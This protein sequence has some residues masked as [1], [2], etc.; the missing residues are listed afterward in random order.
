[1]KV[2]EHA[3]LAGVGASGFGTACRR[4]ES[5]CVPQA[6]SYVVQ[7]FADL[8]LI[9]VAVSLA[10]LV[11]WALAVRRTFGSAA[12]SA[13]GVTLG[14]ARGLGGSPEAA[15][16]RAGLVTLLAI[17]VIFGVHSTIDWTWFV[18]GAALPALL[19]AG[20]LAGR[21]PLA[22]EGSR[23]AGLGPFTEPGGRLGLTRR[24]TEAPLRTAGALG[25]CT[26]A[27]LAAWIVWQPQRSWNAQL[28]ATSALSNGQAG[29]ALTDAR[30]AVASEPF[31][32]LARETLSAVYLAVGDT[33]AARHQL[34]EETTIQPSNFESWLDLGQFD[35]THGRLAD[36]RAE[37][38]RARSL[39]SHEDW[40]ALLAAHGLPAGLCSP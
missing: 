3:V 5:G 20:W 28:A 16:E 19:C 17:V 9:G 35:A 31:D 36:A 26:L 11:A 10:L 21:G 14:S 22:Q 25:L 13:R 39:D 8:G 40:C 1:L 24:L 18:P 12:G 33:A 30:T 2:G 6:H 34:V 4:Y 37:L 15:V 23:I 32:L 38:A 27:V 29:A 7:T